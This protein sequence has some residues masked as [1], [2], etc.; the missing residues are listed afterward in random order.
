MFQSVRYNWKHTPMIAFSS[1]TVICLARSTAAATCCWCCNQ[2]TATM[3][4]YV[5]TDMHHLHTSST[6]DDRSKVFIS[7]LQLSRL[8]RVLYKIVGCA[9]VCCVS[10][11]FYIS[12]GIFVH[13]VPTE[14]S[15]VPPK[16]TICT[17]SGINVEWWSQEKREQQEKGRA[18][19]RDGLSVLTSFLT[20]Q[21]DRFRLLMQLDA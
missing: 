16:H 10:R 14:N 17:R 6:S 18:R 7:T 9:C 13:C 12:L 8:P 21:N 20:T 15:N 2:T 19:E 4:T 1:C 5:I 11:C 3:S